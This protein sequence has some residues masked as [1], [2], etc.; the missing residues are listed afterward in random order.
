MDEIK[1]GKVEIL[2]IS[3]EAVV[4]GEKSTGFGQSMES[5]FSSFVFDDLSSAARK[6]GCENNPRINSNG[7]VT[8][9]TKHC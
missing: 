5:Q 3:P 7:N 4:S 1:N 6:I 9:A 8:N 2:L